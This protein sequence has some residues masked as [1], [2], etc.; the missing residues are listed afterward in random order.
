LQKCGTLEKKRPL[1]KYALFGKALHTWKNASYFEKCCR[2]GK[3]QHTWK[4][5]AHLKK[6]QH[7]WKSVPHQ[8]KYT[9]LGKMHRSWRSAGQVEKCHIREKCATLGKIYAPLL[10]KC[11][12]PGKMRLIFNPNKSVLASL[13]QVNHSAHLKF[14]AKTC[15]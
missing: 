15:G 5:A 14:G 7:T 10:R 8:Q 1:G 6:M 3:A 11:I 13:K 2:S 12:T 9:T 4:N